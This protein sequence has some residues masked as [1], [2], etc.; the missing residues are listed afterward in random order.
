MSSSP[1][2]TVADLEALP[3]QLDDTRYEVID[4]ELFVAEQPHWAHQYVSAA[5]AAALEAWN[6]LTRRGIA[7]IAPGVIF[8]PEDAVAPDVVWISR[9]RAA[10]GLWPDG[11]LHLAP[12]LSAEVL[13]PGSANERRD[14]EVKLKLYAREGVEE[15]WLVDWRARTVEIYRRAGKLLQLAQTLTD[16]D[17]LTSPLLLGFAYPV[18]DLRET[19]LD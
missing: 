12:E 9:E 10:R 19:S 3:D 16:A 18:R 8:S 1:R 17:H 2:F 4:G 7:N 6:G 5:L 15:Y 14:R 13:S 11:K